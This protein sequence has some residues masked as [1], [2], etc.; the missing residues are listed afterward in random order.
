MSRRGWQGGATA[1]FSKPRTL[2]PA[3]EI[4]QPGLNFTLPAVAIVAAI[5][6]LRPAIRNAA[7]WQATVTPLASIIGSGFW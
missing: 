4:T 6:L 3:P 7:F 5:I 2:Y 1:V